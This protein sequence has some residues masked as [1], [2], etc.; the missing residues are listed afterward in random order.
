MTNETKGTGGSSVSEMLSKM[1]AFEKMSGQERGKYIRKV[2]SQTRR[3]K[4]SDEEY[5]LMMGADGYFQNE[6]GEFD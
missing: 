3:A 2:T 5:A 6:D 1:Q 4:L